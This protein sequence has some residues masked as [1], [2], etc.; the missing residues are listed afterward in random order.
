MRPGLLHSAF[1]QRSAR[2]AVKLVNPSNKIKPKA[3]DAKIGRPKVTTYHNIQ[4]SHPTLLQDS[5]SLD[6]LPGPPV[7][8]C[9]EPQRYQLLVHQML[10]SGSFITIF[11]IS[12][13]T[14][15]YV[16]QCNTTKALLIL[17]IICTYIH[18]YTY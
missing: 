1:L 10:H 13:I 11:S 12:F 8:Q 15:T 5:L 9:P 4:S 14:F 7:S 17:V 3:R 6:P 2:H 18:T 16:T